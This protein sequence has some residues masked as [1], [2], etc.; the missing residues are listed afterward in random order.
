MWSQ[1]QSPGNPPVGTPA[2]Q[3]EWI[4]ISY[5]VLIRTIKIPDLVTHFSGWEVEFWSV[6]AQQDLNILLICSSRPVGS[7]PGRCSGGSFVC[8]E[9]KALTRYSWALVLNGYVASLD[10]GHLLHAAH[11]TTYSWR[12]ESPEGSSWCPRRSSHRCPFQLSPAASSSAGQ[13]VSNN[14]LSR[15]ILCPCWLQ[16]VPIPHF[17][18]YK[19]IQKDVWVEFLNGVKTETADLWHIVPSATPEPGKFQTASG[20]QVHP[21]RCTWTSCM[22][23]DQCAWT[24]ET[25]MLEKI[26]K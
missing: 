1:P 20:P 4:Q 14:S 7:F 8:K 26:N 3:A 6:G 15:F 2:G 22:E 21:G 10:G 25:N 17:L 5:H 24:T 11:N 18:S 12:W 9:K 16:S 19:E 23:K 13:G